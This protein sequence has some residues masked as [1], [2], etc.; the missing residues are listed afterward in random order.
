MGAT[1]TARFSAR[2]KGLTEIRPGNYAYFDRTQVGVGSAALERLR[3]HRP[4]ARRQPAG[5]RSDHFRQRQQDV[6]ERRGARL[7]AARGAWRGCSRTSTAA[8][9]IRR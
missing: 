9:R 2:E 4:R 7:H 3:P 5:A 1:P 8:N 6:D